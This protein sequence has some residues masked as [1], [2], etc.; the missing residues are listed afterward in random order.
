MH[1]ADNELH[2]SASVSKRW[3]EAD[4]CVLLTRSLIDEWHRS[5]LLKVYIFK[6]VVKRLFDRSS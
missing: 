1:D 5:K 3:L 6:V 2:G 4:M